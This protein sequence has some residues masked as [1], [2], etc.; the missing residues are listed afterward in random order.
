MTPQTENQLH[1]LIVTGYSGAGKSTVLRALEDIGFF[2]VD[3]LPLALL[4]SFYNHI[5]ETNN[6]T[7]R[8]A[9]GIDIRGDH[10]MQQLVDE[11][12]RYK[13]RGT[14]ISIFFL[15]SSLQVLLR[16]FQ[17]TRRQ[18]PLAHNQDVAG[19]IEQEKKLMQPLIEMADLVLDTDQLTIHQLRT[20]VRGS[21]AHGTTHRMLLNLVSFGFKY[22][23][24]MESNF[25]YDVRSLPNPYFIPEL[26]I[27]TGNDQPVIDYLF[28]Q[29]ETL[30]YWHKLLDF[31]SYAIDRAYQEGRFFMRIA[32]GCTGGR[33][34]SVA[35]VQRLALEL[36]HKAHCIVEHR[37]IA[38]DTY[39]VTV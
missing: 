11:I 9:L 21:F 35:L 3:N 39:P 27:L 6:G 8:V 19:A 26:K 30:E 32:I 10:A 38:H 4:D 24:P 15:T 2:C 25:V 1:I 17:E 20:F 18:H 12:K 22:G 13:L 28:A 23:V 5:V 31:S 36:A 34:R 29:P 14:S 33:H 16:R 37:D 7:Q